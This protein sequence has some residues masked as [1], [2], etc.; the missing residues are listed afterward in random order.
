MMEIQYPQGLCPVLSCPPGL[1]LLSQFIKDL[2]E[3]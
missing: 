1:A 2:S 3:Y